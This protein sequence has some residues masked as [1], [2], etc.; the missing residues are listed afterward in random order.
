MIKKIT[1]LILSICLMATCFAACGKENEGLDQ[2]MQ[3]QGYTEEELNYSE[4]ENEPIKS[5]FRYKI[6]SVDSGKAIA[7]D[8]VS[9]QNVGLV[10]DN[11]SLYENSAAL[12]RLEKQESGGYSIRNAYSNLS[13]STI[14]SG[15][16][17]RLIQAARE[18]EICFNIV[19]SG[20]AFQIFSADGN[21]LQAKQASLIVTKMKQ[22]DNSF[23]FRLEEI[24]EF[25]KLGA[26]KI[27]NSSGKA[28]YVDNEKQVGE[29]TF[30]A[31]HYEQWFFTR[32]RLGLY[33]LTNIGSCYQLGTAG[34]TE[35]T[36]DFDELGSYTVEEVSLNRYK[37]IDYASGK[38]I[39]YENGLKFRDRTEEK[40][41]SSV[42]TILPVCENYPVPR[43]VK[44][45]M[46]RTVALQR[47][48]LWSVPSNWNNIQRFPELRPV[49][50]WYDESVPIVTDWE[51]NF[52]A[53]YGIDFTMSCWY[54]DCKDA[55]YP[56]TVVGVYDNYVETYEQ[57][58]WADYSKYAIMFTHKTVES[59]PVYSVIGG[60]DDWNN[61]MAPYFVEMFKR[62][63]YKKIDNKPI[64]VMFRMEV[65]I[66]E[67][68]GEENMKIAI[69]RLDSLAKEAGFDGVH[70]IGQA[71]NETETIVRSRKK[72]MGFDAIMSYHLPTLTFNSLPSN[73]TA[74]QIIECHETYWQ[75]NDPA[76]PYMASVSVGWD[77][78]AWGNS[79][80]SKKW[81]LTPSEYA[82]L[83]QKA[84]EYG[85]GKGEYSSEL[86]WLDNWNEYGEGHSIMP[87]SRQGFGYLEAIYNTLKA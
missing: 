64:F 60:L 69:D 86:I 3:Y 1:V 73:P 79:H 23:L 56:D 39:Y 83:L 65:A 21:A 37:L 74:E 68:G 6:V 71:C 81:R 58:E 52:T 41:G 49:L 50:G 34:E 67:I 72:E 42:F 11:E 53:S 59:D 57:A 35:M 70:F 9:G 75:D 5:Y 80:S 16:S 13:L 82:T 19:Q 87:D 29:K 32:S 55:A 61:V 10:E 25:E 24:R 33:T 84:K 46:S 7:V 18:K 22:G 2:S 51:I 78:I 40:Q 48:D 8:S 85:E 62:P 76:I 43:P 26:Y 54:R 20:E 63:N 45:K 15:A 66:Q 38:E 44:K 28:L 27:L 14:Q 17:Q 4:Q 36:P 47:C 31:T 77:S 12:W 30:E